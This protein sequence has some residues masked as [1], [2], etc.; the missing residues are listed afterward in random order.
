MTPRL[1]PKIFLLK[2]ADVLPKAQHLQKAIK[3]I[4]DNMPNTAYDPNF[5]V[6]PNQTA[7]VKTE[8]LQ[9]G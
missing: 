5:A 3:N 4:L 1:H 6:N 7:Q 9:Q 8:A 2:Q